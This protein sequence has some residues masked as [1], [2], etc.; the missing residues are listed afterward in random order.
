MPPQS[1]PNLETH[2]LQALKT[3]GLGERIR[4]KLAGGFTAAQIFFRLDKQIQDE[5]KPES[6][7]PVQAKHQAISKIESILKQLLAT[8]NVKKKTV[9][10]QE[11]DGR[12]VRRL[13]IDVYR[14]T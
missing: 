13:R 11:Q 2:V 10:I 12:G 7:D 9:N 14:R 4:I 8:K 3:R 1:V 5:I 6:T